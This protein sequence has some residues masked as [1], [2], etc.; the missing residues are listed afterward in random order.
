[1]IHSIFA[2]SNPYQGIVNIRNLLRTLPFGAKHPSISR[3]LLLFSCLD[4][5]SCE[6]SMN[7]ADDFELNL[8]IW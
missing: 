6:R 8:Y 1:M 4:G 5:Y 3:F 7:G 2:A